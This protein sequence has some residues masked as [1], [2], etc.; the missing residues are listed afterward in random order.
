V[1]V[2]PE[3][4]E[5]H[6]ILYAGE[7]EIRPHEGLVLATGRALTLSVRE[8]ELLAAMARRQ[9]TI[10]TRGELYRTV[11]GSELRPGD[12]QVDVYVA[13]LRRKLRTAM[14]D[15]RFIHTEHGHGYRFQLEP[16]PENAARRRRA[17]F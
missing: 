15:R 12:R 14:P 9:G 1:A 13:K 3:R 7:L 8:L 17:G 6:E 11:W 2:Y 5:V 16:L 4:S 10:I